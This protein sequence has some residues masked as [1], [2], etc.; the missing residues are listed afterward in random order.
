MNG[1]QEVR[2]SIPLIST[3]DLTSLF[4]LVSFLCHAFFFHERNHSG[5]FS[6][7]RRSR[8]RADAVLT[9]IFGAGVRSMRYHRGLLGGECGL[10]S[11]LIFDYPERSRC[12]IRSHWR[13]KTACPGFAPHFT[14]KN[15]HEAV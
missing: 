2:G 9:A 8:R 5:N 15:D 4:R 1:I 7:N 6:M 12:T 10:H 11:P 3:T 13:A 14:T